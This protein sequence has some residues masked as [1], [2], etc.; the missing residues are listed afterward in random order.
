MSLIA[1]GLEHGHIKFDEEQKY[2][3]YIA[4]SKRYR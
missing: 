4:P 3:T 2:I 1:K